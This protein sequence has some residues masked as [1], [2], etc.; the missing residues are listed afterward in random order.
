[1]TQIYR[2]YSRARLGWFPF[3][4]TGWQA[5]VVAAATLPVF[6]SL[7]EQAW[8]PAGMFLLIGATVTAVTVVPV[9]GRSAIGWIAASAAFAVGAL[10]GWTTFRSRAADRR[11]RRTWPRSTCP[12]PWPASRSTRAHRSG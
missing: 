4:L 5:G 9:R 7:K 12:A 2:Q 8:A 1:M 3:G 6:W 11:R 10:A